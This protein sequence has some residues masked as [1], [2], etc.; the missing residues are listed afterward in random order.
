MPAMQQS[1]GI[2]RGRLDLDHPSAKI[3]KN[4]RSTR[5]RNKRGGINDNKIF[6]E[7]FHFSL[8]RFR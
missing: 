5:A 7:A 8:H 1:I 4:G 2:A 6:K 3:G